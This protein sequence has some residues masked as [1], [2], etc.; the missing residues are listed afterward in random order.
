MLQPCNLYEDDD[1]HEDDG[2]R[3]GVSTEP[4]NVR[5]IVA[6]TKQ[7]LMEPGMGVHS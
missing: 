2:P 5:A 3:D 7:D 4:E 6:I 1:G